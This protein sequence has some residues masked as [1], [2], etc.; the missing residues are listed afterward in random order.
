MNDNKTETVQHINIDAIAE[1]LSQTPGVDAAYI[2][3]SAARG[4][5][6]P[7][8]DLDIAILPLQNAPFTDLERIELGTALFSACGRIADTGI[9]SSKNLVYAKEAILT[10]KRIYARNRVRADEAAANLLGMYYLFNEER[11]EVLN[12]YRV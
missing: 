10:G 7:D 8:S 3:G 1:I 6:R 2:L 4:S 12:A 5:M 9:L 11:S